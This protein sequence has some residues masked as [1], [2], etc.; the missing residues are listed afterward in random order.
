M[1]ILGC[2]PILREGLRAAAELEQLGFSAGVYSVPCIKP[3][4][5]AGIKELAS[6][7]PLL[8][9]L[10]EHQVTGGLG[11]AVAEVLGEISGP[12]ARLSRLGLQDTWSSVV[13]SWEYLLAQYGLTG[14]QIAKTVVR[15][16][17]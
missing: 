10:E 4:D 8:M 2:D 17:R 6:A 5:V 16:L 7:Y 12:C 11:S 9:T 14:P 15:L 1:A 13:G 3:L